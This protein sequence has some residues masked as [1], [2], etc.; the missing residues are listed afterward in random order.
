MLVGILDHHHRCID[1]RADRN[2]DTAQRQ[3]VGIESLCA[4][5]DERD[6]DA[7][8]QGEDRDERRT[9]VPEEEAADER[10]D[11]ELLSK[12]FAEIVDRAVDQP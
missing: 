12:L 11:H 9:G 2:R 7:K 3:D 4:H 1:H 5:H 6:Q 10:N 8:R